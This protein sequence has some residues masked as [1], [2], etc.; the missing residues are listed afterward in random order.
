MIVII[1]PDN[2]NLQLDYLILSDP[3]SRLFP[4]PTPIL[5]TCDMTCECG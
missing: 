4:C 2:Y 3:I 5:S 1:F